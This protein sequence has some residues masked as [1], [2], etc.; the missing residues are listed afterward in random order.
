MAKYVLQITSSDTIEIK[1]YNDYKTINDLVGGW[2]EICGYLKPN[3]MLYC[4]EEFLYHDECSFNAL[5]TIINGKQPIYGNTVLMID[6][7]TD[8]EIPERD[9]LP[10]E[11]EKAKRIKTKLDFFIE[12]ERSLINELHKAYDNC[13][14]IINVDTELDI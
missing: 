2:Y 6:G 1:E 14:P 7:Y 5:A 4:N 10:I 8:S 11:L 13:K 12:S 3:Y 9:T